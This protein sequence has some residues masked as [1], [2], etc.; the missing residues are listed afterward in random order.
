MKDTYTHGKFQNDVVRFQSMQTLPDWLRILCRRLTHAT[1]K[2]R[3]ELTSPRKSAW[4]GVSITFNSFSF[5]EMV[6]TCKR[7]Y[8]NHDFVEGRKHL[9]KHDLV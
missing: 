9:T 4:P 1:V 3:L 5:H 2:A 6:V 8:E 7:L